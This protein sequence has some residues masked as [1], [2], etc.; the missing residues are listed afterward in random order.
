M[1]DG[2][3]QSCPDFSQVTTM[4]GPGHPFA[5]VVGTFSQTLFAGGTLL[6]RKRAAEAAFEQAAANIGAPS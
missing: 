2:I 6:H 4:F 3:E 5:Y 1:G